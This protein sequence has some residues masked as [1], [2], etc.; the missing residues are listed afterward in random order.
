[1]SLGTLIDLWVQS[2]KMEEDSGDN[3]DMIS[4]PRY[5]AERPIVR[6]IWISF[7]AA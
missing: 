6:K 1:M 5:P 2:G 7:L 3:W 4:F